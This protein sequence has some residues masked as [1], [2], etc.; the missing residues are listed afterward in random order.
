MNLNL[1]QQTEYFI[2]LGQ[3]AII[4]WLDFMQ[5][6]FFL[7]W[8]AAPEGSMTYHSTQGN[9]SDPMSLSP[10]PLKPQIRRL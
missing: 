8:A 7:F 6:D 2:I 10:P 3:L 4:E 1:Y 5:R 9:F